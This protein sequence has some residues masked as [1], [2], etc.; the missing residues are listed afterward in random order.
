M[1]CGTGRDCGDCGVAEESHTGASAAAAAAVTTGVALDG[2]PAEDSFVGVGGLSPTHESNPGRPPHSNQGSPQFNPISPEFKCG[3]PES[4]QTPTD[5]NSTWGLPNTTQ[6]H[7]SSGALDWESCAEFRKFENGFFAS[8]LSFPLA[9]DVNVF[10]VWDV[11]ALF[12]QISMGWPLSHRHL[13]AG[14]W[15]RRRLCA[16]HKQGCAKCQMILLELI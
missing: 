4:N 16:G 3:L 5:L 13:F 14:G 1:H 7:T 11:V 9:F 6:E 15:N 2:A 8:D 10:I 12:W